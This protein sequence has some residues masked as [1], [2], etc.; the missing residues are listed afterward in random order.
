MALEPRL[1]DVL[2]AGPR[3]LGDSPKLSLSPATI[4]TR[5]A[6]SDASGH[7]CIKLLDITGHHGMVTGLQGQ[8]T[9][10]PAHV[11]ALSVWPSSPRVPAQ[12]T[13]TVAFRHAGTECH[14]LRNILSHTQAE[15][16][17]RS[18]QDRILGGCV[19]MHLF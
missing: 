5:T 17:L 12:G 8:A 13:V 1:R 11:R 19:Q 14:S 6:Q 7:Y 3:G 9:S 15:L 16:E 10:V 4:L 2:E 18:Q